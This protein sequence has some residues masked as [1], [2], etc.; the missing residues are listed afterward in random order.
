[1]FH[2]P[3]GKLICTQR[4]PSPFI[5]LLND[6]FSI[7]TGFTHQDNRGCMYP[8]LKLDKRPGCNPPLTSPLGGMIYLPVIQFPGGWPN[9]LD[10]QTDLHRCHQSLLNRFCTVQPHRGLGL[11]RQQQVQ[12]MVRWLLS[13]EWSVSQQAHRPAAHVSFT[14]EQ[15]AWDFVWS[16]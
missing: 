13:V 10:N 5:H 15:T 6:A 3:A 11:I 12:M 1:M 4:S 7:L 8:Q 2:D 16:M 9:Y 14:P